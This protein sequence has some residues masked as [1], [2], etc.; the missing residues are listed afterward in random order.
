MSIPMSDSVLAAII[1]GT[2]TLSAS[3]LQLR[4]ASVRGGG[5]RGS[6]FAIRFRSRLTQI[7][8]LGVIAGA[9]VAGF[10][11]SQ[12]LTE[13]ERA[14]AANMQRELQ[15]RIAEVSHTAGEL[16]QTRTDA[17]AEI[18]SD[19]VRRIGT[20]GVIVTATVAACRPAIPADAAPVQTAAAPPAPHA[21]AEADASP[22]ILCATIPA[23]ATVTDVGLF[24]RPAEAE[25]PLSANRFLPGQEADQ[26]RF[27]EK[28]SEGAPEADTRQVCQGF[29]NWSTTHARTVRVV[30]HYSLP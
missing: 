25:T 12:W 4:S 29:S 1:A 6:G 28:Y 21:C 3:L 13:G 26:A 24:S 18:E 9:A 7:L 14:A 11:A 30:F 27:S 8:L 17:R 23:N 20:E 22:L 16:E 10:G 15:A 5:S 19:F 2:A